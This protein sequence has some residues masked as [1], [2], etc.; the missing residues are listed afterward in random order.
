MSLS[1]MTLKYVMFSRMT[2]NTMILRRNMIITLKWCHNI[3]TNVTQ[4]D[5]TQ[6]CRM[7]VSRMTINIIILRRK[8]L[9]I[10]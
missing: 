9:S 5:D 7:I 4:Q 2:I 10:T 1:R 3:R 6:I 8:I